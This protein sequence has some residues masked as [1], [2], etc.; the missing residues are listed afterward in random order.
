VTA[1]HRDLAEIA[2]G[3][4]TRA[5]AAEQIDV[6]VGRSSSTSVRVFDGA[7]EAFTSAR[8]AA[9]GVRVIVDGRV[10]FAHAG[11]IDTDVLDDV[12]REARE[13]VAFAERDEFAGLAEPDGVEP[14]MHEHWNQAIVDLT[15]EAKIGW[16]LDLERRVTTLDDRVTSVRT[17]GW[18]DG[19]GEVAY[20]TSTGFVRSDRGTS[21]S[22]G[23]QPLARAGGE[24]QIGYAGDAARDPDAI[25]VG[26]VAAEAV[27]RATRLLGSTKPPSARLQILLDPR[28]VGALLGIVS[29]MLDGESVIKG[30][31]PFAGRVG[32]AIASPLLNLVDDP[33]RTESLGADSWDGEGLACRRNSLI[34]AGQLQGFLHNSWTARRSGTVS[35]GSAVR[36]TRSVPGVAARVLVLDPGTRSF[37]EL[38]GSIDLGLYVNSFA[39]L[40]SGVNPVSGDFSVGADGLMIRGGSLAEPVREVTIA[41]TLQRLLLDI[42]EVGGDAEWLPS[43]DYLASL[44]IDDVS[45]GGS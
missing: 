22:V 28:L 6:M 11:S 32:E 16:A 34:D 1:D 2:A 21:C 5:T 14:V 42:A 25:D 40:H 29:G 30:R 36:G 39:G 45:M 44:V 26:K 19:A 33:T 8:N 38:V 3:L 17:A 10:G 12:L 41:S 37:D 18:S 13:N 9:V 15:P 7:V 4:A 24:T 20:A 43:G 27:E 35:T 23:V 31:S